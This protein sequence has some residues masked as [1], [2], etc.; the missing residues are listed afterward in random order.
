MSPLD[1]EKYIGKVNEAEIVANYTFETLNKD[2]A[3]IKKKLDLILKDGAKV[4]LADS[5]LY[6]EFKNSTHGREDLQ[7]SELDKSLIDAVL[8]VWGEETTIETPA[9]E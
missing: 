6:M 3:F 7:K 9:A 4:E 5:V 8:L 2:E 1:L